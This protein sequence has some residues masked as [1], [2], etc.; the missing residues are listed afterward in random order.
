MPM[1]PNDYIQKARAALTALGWSCEESFN[2]K[3]ECNLVLIKDGERKAW[4]MFDQ[5]FCWSEAYKT[6]TGRS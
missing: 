2:E 1:N 3:G 6:I 4:G 5:I